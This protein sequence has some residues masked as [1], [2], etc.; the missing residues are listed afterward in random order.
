[1]SRLR[2]GLSRDIDYK[3]KKNFHGFFIENLKNK[4]NYNAI[5]ITPSTQLDHKLINKSKKLKL[6]FIMSL[7][8]ITEIDLKKL[9]KDIKILWFGKKSKQVLKKINATPEFIFGLIILLSKNFLN[10]QN[11]IY[12]NTWQ[13]RDTAL[14]SFEKMLSNS[15]IGIIGYGRIGKKLKSIA[16]SFGIETLVYSNKKIKNKKS[17]NYIAENA[18]FVT[19]N[20]SLNSSTKNFIDKDFFRKMKKNSYFI[21]TAKGEIVNYKHL[22]KYLG[23]NIKGAAVDVYKME[24]ASHREFQM[25]HT[26]ANKNNNLILTPHVAG[27]TLDS[28]V[29]LQEHSLDII[30]DYFRQMQ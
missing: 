6:I 2:I 30:K 23:K 14:Q 15:T 29:K 9:R 17:L 7:H 18:D 10:I 1:M 8:L 16:K 22:V 11:T 20:L 26:Y 4:L 13:P 24:R 28:L 21:N 12:K 3:L 25:L 27:G 5:I 19:I